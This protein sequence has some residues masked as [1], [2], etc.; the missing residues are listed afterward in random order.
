VYGDGIVGLPGTFSSSWADR[1]HEDFLMAYDEGAGRPDGLIAR[2]PNRYYLAVHPERVRGFVELV[3]APAVVELSSSVLGDDYQVVELGFDVALA[4]AVDQP[5]HRDFPIPPETRV[6]HRLTSLAFNASTVDVTPDLAPFE[7]APGTHWDAGEDFADGMFP[8]RSRWAAFERLA[9][10]RYPRRGDL[11]A[12]TGLALHRGTTNHAGRSRP[13]L[14][15]GVVAAAGE[16]ND[17]HQLAMTRGFYDQLP[18]LVR[19]R[20]RVALVHELTPIVQ[21]HDIGGLRMGS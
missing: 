5:W 20:L 3:S 1:L 19:D 12:R 9:S 15:L 14:V 13:V 4:G 11:S 17:V 7:I 2:G 6:E 21:S 10:R 18:E 8:P 16:Q